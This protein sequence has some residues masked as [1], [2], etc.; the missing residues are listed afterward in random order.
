MLPGMKRHIF[1][2]LALILLLTGCGQLE[3]IPYSPPQTPDSWLTIQPY[4]RLNLLGH[5]VIL[6]QPMSTPFVYALGLLAIAI[7]LRCLARLAAPAVAPLVGRGPAAL[8]RRGAAG[9]HQL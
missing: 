7:G 9:R 1:F 2:W 5:E 6:V 4:A 8:G 3:T